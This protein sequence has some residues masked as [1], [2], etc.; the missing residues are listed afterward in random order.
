MT[1]NRLT[2]WKLNLENKKKTFRGIRYCPDFLYGKLKERK[3]QY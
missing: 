3:K 2:G 1:K